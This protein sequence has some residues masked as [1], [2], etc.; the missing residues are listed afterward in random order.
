MKQFHII[1]G[2]VLKPFFSIHCCRIEI[3]NSVCKHV[4]WKFYAGRDQ[5]VNSTSCHPTTEA[6][7][8]PEGKQLTVRETGLIIILQQQ[9]ITDRIGKLILE[10][11]E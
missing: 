3:E 2:I 11:F 7:L 1:T 9:W 4:R 10:E 8:L 6:Q 5:F